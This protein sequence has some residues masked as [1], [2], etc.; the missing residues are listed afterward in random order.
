MFVIM[1]LRRPRWDMKQPR[2]PC[3]KGAWE[4]VR[5]AAWR[6]EGSQKKPLWTAV[7]NTLLCEYQCVA[8]AHRLSVLWY[9][10]PAVGLPGLSTVPV[11]QTG[12]APYVRILSDPL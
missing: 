6:K 2:V 5:I 4:T 12:L 9:E 8:H 10:G 3:R 11:P 1:L 7:L